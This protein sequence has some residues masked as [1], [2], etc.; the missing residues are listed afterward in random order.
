M[1]MKHNF[2]PDI[3]FPLRQCFERIYTIR[4]GK[5]TAAFLQLFENRLNEIKL[6]VLVQSFLIKFSL[7]MYQVKLI[8]L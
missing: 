5:S 6:T 7:L 1:K 4:G 2:D 3:H 8:F